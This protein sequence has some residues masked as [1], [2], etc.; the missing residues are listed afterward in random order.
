MRRPIS[1]VLVWLSLTAVC[2]GSL[3]SQESDD[4]WLR[5]CQR[6]EYGDRDHE[7]LCEVRLSGFR[8]AGSTLRFEPDLNGGVEIRGWDRDSVAITARIQ[9]SARTVEAAR[10]LA[11][12]IQVSVRERS[13]VSVDGPSTRRHEGW[14]VV[15][16]VQVPRIVNLE[17]RVTNGPLSVDDVSGTL[18]LRATNGPVS[19]NRVAGDVRARVQNGPLSVRLAGTAWDG[20]GLDAEAVN[21]PVDLALPDNYN[22]ELETGTINGPTD[23][24]V[25]LTVTL[26]GRRSDRI[27]TTLGKGGAPIRVVTTNGPFTIRRARG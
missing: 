23:F 26:L 22:A 11:R 2:A 8:P 10:A 1:A 16:V 27:R 12:D 24:Q 6:G 25:P 14:G 7:Q 19:L 4:R 3:M 13:T 5:D 21:G 20:K 17:A 9:T 15:L 18:D